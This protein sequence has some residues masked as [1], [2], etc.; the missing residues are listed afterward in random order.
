MAIFPIKKKPEKKPKAQDS[1]KQYTALR[2]KGD[3]WG[4]YAKRSEAWVLFGNEK[5]MK[6]RADKL[7]SMK[8]QDNDDFRHAVNI[9]LIVGT[10]L[11]SNDITMTDENHKKLLEEAL[12]YFHETLDDYDL[13]GAED[14]MPTPNEYQFLFRDAKEADVLEDDI[15]GFVEDY[16]IEDKIHDESQLI[17]QQDLLDS[18]EEDLTLSVAEYE[19]KHGLPAGTIESE[20]AIL[21]EIHEALA[22]T[23]T[24]PASQEIIN[25]KLPIREKISNLKNNINSDDA[26]IQDEELT[27]EELWYVLVDGDY[28]TEAELELLT[29]IN[30]YSIE[31]LNDAIQARYGYS[32][33]EQFAEDRLLDSKIPFETIFWGI[34]DNEFDLPFDKTVEYIHEKY[35]DKIW[36][37]ENADGDLSVL[38]DEE[39]QDIIE[40]AKDE[41][42]NWDSIDIYNSHARYKSDQAINDQLEKY[43]GIKNTKMYKMQDNKINIPELLKKEIEALGDKSRKAD[44]DKAIATIKANEAYP[45]VYDVY[46]GSL[47]E[48]ERD[49]LLKALRN[50]KDLTVF[51]YGGML[52]VLTK[53]DE[54]KLMEDQ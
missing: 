2:Y 29:D 4:I 33:Y 15:I 19:D 23:F 42:L 1:D 38:T 8:I 36:Q 26:K 54:R 39:K 31:T 11:N 10:Y 25:A 52:K 46:T 53:E 20:E 49:N 32:D 41:A 7:N 18:L 16:N 48:Q 21:F 27:V 47:I 14:Y 5:D 6:A 44:L 9:E 13:R 34:Y 3:E 17:D 30:G 45:M 12:S 22:T 35:A 50:N 51:D 28:F 24:D 40:F 37:D 43:F